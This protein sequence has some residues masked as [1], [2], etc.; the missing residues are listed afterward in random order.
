MVVAEENG[1]LIDV[2]NVSPS[3]DSP[4]DVMELAFLHVLPEHQGRGIGSALLAEAQR[5]GQS[6][7]FR[8]AVVWVV[9]S[10]YA[11]RNF[12]ERRGWVHTGESVRRTGSGWSVE[13]LRY[14]LAFT[15]VRPTK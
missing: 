3:S 7:G 11:A 15:E 9:D 10:H 14:R 13:E 12:Y 6:G 5:I 1:K 2:V 4:A 8:H